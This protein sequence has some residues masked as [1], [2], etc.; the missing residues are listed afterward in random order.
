MYVKLTPIAIVTMCVCVYVC[1]CVCVCVFSLQQIPAV[2]MVTTM[3]PPVSI[4]ILSVRTQEQLGTEI[5]QDD[6]GR[7]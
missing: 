1:V 5:Q 6:V 2:S 3:S 7:N 4:P